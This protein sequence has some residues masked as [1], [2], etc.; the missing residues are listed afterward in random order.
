VLELIAVPGLRSLALRTAD[1][2]ERLDAARIR[3]ALQD[4]RPT[5]VATAIEIAARGR[6]CRGPRTHARN[7][8]A[9][10]A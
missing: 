1:R 6:R 4:S 8:S 5:V 9:L 10:S 2:I 3:E 7:R